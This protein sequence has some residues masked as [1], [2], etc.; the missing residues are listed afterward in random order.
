MHNSL[1]REYVAVSVLP[2]L[3]PQRKGRQWEGTPNSTQG[4]D[5]AVSARQDGSQQIPDECRTLPEYHK[6]SHL[7]CP[8][9]LDLSQDGGRTGV[10]RLRNPQ[11]EQ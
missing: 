11:S 6:T 9:V 5:H 1:T 7:V 10:Y 4:N 2:S 3:E 8:E